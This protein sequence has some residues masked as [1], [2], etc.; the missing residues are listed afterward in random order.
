MA[1]ETKAQM[2]ERLKKEKDGLDVLENIYVYA[3]LGEE[4]TEEDIIR[5][6]WYGLYTQ[7]RNLQAEDDPTLYFMLRIKLV[8]G[9]LN[10]E[11][12]EMVAQISEEFAR[13]TADFT[14]RQDIQLHYI[15]VVDLPKIFTLLNSVGLSTIFAAGDTPRNIV[16]CPVNGIDHDEIA[17]VRA[18]VKKLNEAIEGNKN[19]S[20]LPRKFKMG[21][22]GCSKHCMNHEIQDVSFNAVKVGEN[23]IQFDLSVGGG[24]ASNKRIATHIGFIT[25]SQVVPTAKAILKIYRDFG[26]RESRTKARLGHLID[27]WGVEKF[28]ETLQNELNF[29]I[30]EPQEQSY[31]PYAQRE[32][33]GI[34]ESK[35]RNSSFIGC[36]LDSGYI[37]SEG[38]RGLAKVLKDNGASKIRSTTTQNIVIIDAPTPNATKIAEELAEFGIDANPSAFKARTL[39]CTGLSFCKFAVSE[40]KGLAKHI[41]SYLETKFPDFD[42]TISISVNGCPNSCAHPHIVNIG[43]MGTK[44][45]DKD[46]NR[47]NGYELLL[48]GH[49]EGEKSQFAQKTG[50]KVTYEDAPILIE[51]L[52]NEYKNS[53]IS[54]FHEFV[55]KKANEE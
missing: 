46:G 36:A 47:V 6:K 31:T 15:K 43:L 54:T 24:L 1:K 37:G 28:R 25:P 45:K 3:V 7:N 33:F 51:N 30:K 16:S 8:G 50:I 39:A 42:E 35:E 55:T 17:D 10:L 48:A 41:T 19:F 2:N 29:Q 14:T 20:N 38:L 26:N 27:D 22:N 21:V 11:Q 40:T 23:K 52:I 5:F 12:L 49:L 53:G 34:H 32:H 18:T 13:G 9:E 44:V 4:P